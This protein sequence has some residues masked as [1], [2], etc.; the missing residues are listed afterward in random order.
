M[1]GGNSVELHPMHACVAMAAKTVKIICDCA[2]SGDRRRAGLHL[3]LHHC[4]CAVLDVYVAL[5][6]CMPGRDRS[7]QMSI[8]CSPARSV[9]GTLP[10]SGS[11]TLVALATHV[12]SSLHGTALRC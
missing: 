1:V 5:R 6:Y 8:G 12:K 3:T 9:A 2:I 10:N 7:D 11:T 4:A